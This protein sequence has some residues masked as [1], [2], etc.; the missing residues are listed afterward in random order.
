MALQLDMILVNLKLHIQK[1]L[2]MSTF[3][4]FRLEKVL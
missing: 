2:F 4:L 3:A 1:I